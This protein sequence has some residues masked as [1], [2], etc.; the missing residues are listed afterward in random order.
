[1]Y[2]RLFASC[3]YFSVSSCVVAAPI[4]SASVRAVVAFSFLG[5]SVAY[6]LSCMPVYA[7]KLYF[8]SSN[9]A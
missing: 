1:M 6:K 8:H 9:V 4:S 5:R 3:I 7:A 2:L